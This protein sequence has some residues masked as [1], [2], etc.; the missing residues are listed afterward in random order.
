MQN[1]CFS[2]KAVSITYSEHV[3]VALVIQRAKRLCRI[4]SP[5]A[6]PPVPNCFILSHKWQDFRE[7]KLLN[8]KCVFSFSLQHQFE[9]FLILR[10]IQRQVA[11]N[12]NMSSC[13][14]SLILVRF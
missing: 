7:K 9:T 3:L 6:R 10:R 11:I 12:L 13:K 2:A 1:H 14:V 4:M 8:M 5:V